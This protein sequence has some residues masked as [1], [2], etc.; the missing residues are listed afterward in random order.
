VSYDVTFEQSKPMG[1]AV[2]NF[3]LFRL[4]PVLCRY[5]WWVHSC[6]LCSSTISTEIT[7]CHFHL[8]AD[9]VQLYKS[10]NLKT[11]EGLIN[12]YLEYLNLALKFYCLKFFKYP[13][14]CAFRVLKKYIHG[15]LPLVL[16]KTELF[17]NDNVVWDSNM[18][19]D[20][21]IHFLLSQLVTLYP[22]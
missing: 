21:I 8:N 19:F 11:F 14:F 18:F 20:D 1:L 16:H 12:L 5:Q 10:S 4:H 2:A 3:C 15:L 17:T 6:L 13:I 22:F 9:D 7:Y